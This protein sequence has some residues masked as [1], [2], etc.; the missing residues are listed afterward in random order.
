MPEDKTQEG[1]VPSTI[2][3]E[4]TAVVEA[5]PE[6]VKV[7]APLTRE[8]V[9]QLLDER[10]EKASRHF[11]SIKDQEVA[12]VGREL[13]QERRR[14]DALE[15]KLSEIDPD[16][17]RTL[18]LETKEK[19]YTELEAQQR[20]EAYAQQLNAN[21]VAHLESLGIDKDDKRVDW[22]KDAADYLGGRSRFDASVAKILKEN[23]KATEVKQAS[24]FKEMEQKLRRDLGLDSVDTS[25][26]GGGSVEGIPT[27]PAKFREW[28]ANISQEEYEK[29][30]ASKV[31]ELRR[32]GRI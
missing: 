27:D 20:Q 31:S 7:P 4:G 3:P 12:K 18:R 16:T 5:K 26:S 32:R 24:S 2:P 22:A 15:T 19:Y 11:Q 9:A 25:V 14:S 17:A 10:V 13:A 6:E 21:L 30:Y 23:Q 28:I 29:K 1:T 8:E